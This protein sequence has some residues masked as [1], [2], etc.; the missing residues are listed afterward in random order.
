MLPSSISCCMTFSTNTSSYWFSISIP[1]LRL[2]HSFLINL[3]IF[4]SWLR[5]SFYSFSAFTHLSGNILSFIHFCHCWWVH[6]IFIDFF[7]TVFRQITNWLM[8]TTTFFVQR[9]MTILLNSLWF[10]NIYFVSIISPSFGPSMILVKIWIQSFKRICLNLHN[11]NA[12]WFHWSC[13][14]ILSII[15]TFFS[16]F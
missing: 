1:R 3:P 12:N 10:N 9:T 2:S 13:I 4:S 8:S 5:L 15:K 7:L 16:L 6:V 11:S 14:M